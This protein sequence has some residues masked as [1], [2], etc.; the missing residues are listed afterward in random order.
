MKLY[1]NLVNAAATTLQDIFI[2]R[3]YADKAIERLL[4]KN[5]QWGSRDRKF[6]AEAVY[7]VVRNYRLY[8][9][10]AGSEKN[11]WFMVAVWLTLKGQEAPAWP[12]FSDYDPGKVHKMHERLITQPEICYSYPDW[13]WQLCAREL[14]NDVWKREAIAMHE[15]AEVF[16]RVNTLKTTRDRLLDE[17]NAGEI[18]CEPVLAVP[19]AIRLTR[20]A[21]VFSH[22]LFKEGWFEVQDVGSQE[23]GYFV[24]AAE[25]ETVI[26]ACAGAG[27]KS[28][29]LAALMKNR[30]RVISL[31]VEAFKLDELR[32]RANRAGA[33]NIDT[34]PIEST[35]TIKSLHRVA[36]RVLLDVP[37]SGLGVI[38]RNPD[39]KWKLTPE[40]LERTAITQEEILSEYPEMVKT[41]GHLFYATCS[42]LP[43]ENE[44]QVKKFVSRHPE[45]EFLE[46]RHILPSQGADGFYM[47]KL[48]RS[49]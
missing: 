33:F 28:L 3:Y 41:G 21:N 45:F 19:D 26:D 13:L 40:V 20:R 32:R 9:T 23:I 10:L 12:E 34:R 7:D 18:H 37:C 39:A 16:L 36:D 42:I 25:G 8:A 49:G 47:A 43:S 1:R 4:K 5:P 31:D 29:H 30:G 2:R 48:R 27:G 15:Q 24:G 6:I 17:L 44:E 11:F 14:G 46:E 38:R 35:K 22:R